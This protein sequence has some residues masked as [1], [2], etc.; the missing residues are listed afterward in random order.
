MDET[1]VINEGG[2]KADI[3]DDTGTG[4]GTAAAVA[5]GGF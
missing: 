1:A 4:T 3:E 2:G 5:R